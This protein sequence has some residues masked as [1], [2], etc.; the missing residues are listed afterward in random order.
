M[1]GRQ[2]RTRTDVR[3]A[4]EGAIGNACADVVAR[5]D[6]GV[7]EIDLRGGG[8]GGQGG[9]AVRVTVARVGVQ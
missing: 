3:L 6:A 2:G 9:S 4:D 1:R 5:S 7:Q 8:G